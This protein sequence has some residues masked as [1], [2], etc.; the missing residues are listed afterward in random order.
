MNAFDFWRRAG[1]RPSSDETTEAAEAQHELGRGRP[2][3]QGVRAR[4]E[5][6]FGRSFEGVRVHTDA[7][8]ARLV[9]RHD[10]AAF[11]VGQDIAFGSGAYRPGDAAGD[12]LIAHEL[13][14]TLQQRAAET[15]SAGDVG[16]EAEATRAAFTALAP[17]AAAPRVSA[18]RLGLQ[19]CVPGGGGNVVTGAITPAHFNFQT[20]V[21]LT[22]T[23]PGGWKA[24]LIYATM[25]NGETGETFSCR[26]EVGVPIRSLDGNVSDADAK[27]AAAAAANAAAYTILSRPGV[28]V[29]AACAPFRAEMQAL[30]GLRIR[31]TRVSAPVSPGLTPT[32]FGP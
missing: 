26:F 25:R 18:G 9:R 32:L 12:V 11:T 8:A 5:R 14:H 6:A 1:R 10:A 22:G 15:E 19:R 16:L 23:E 4:M 13:A 31:G 29:G 27:V 2:L 24:A 3:D 28:V 7:E 21:P 17:G 20:V 30:M